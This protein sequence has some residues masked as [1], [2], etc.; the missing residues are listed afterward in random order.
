MTIP[1]LISNYNKTMTISKLKRSYAVLSNV[2]KL[3]MLDNSSAVLM[4]TV[5]FTDAEKFANDYFLPYFSGA[6]IC[7]SYS[8]CGYSSNTPYLA[9]EGNSW[10]FQVV[11]TS[12]RVPIMTNDGM[13]YWFPIAQGSDS[14][15][16]PIPTKAVYVDINGAQKPNRICADMFVFTREANGIVPYKNPDDPDDPSCV[17]DIIENG[18]AIPDDYPYEF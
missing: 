17:S 10:T 3:S 18:W 2:Y 13:I 8:D 4:N 9:E 16:N 14:E 7:K 12:R 11:Q 15:G 1:N 5:G 6:K